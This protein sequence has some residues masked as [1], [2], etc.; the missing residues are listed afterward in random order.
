VVGG[1]LLADLG[2]S[3]SYLLDSQFY[4]DG[5]LSSIGGGSS[6]E[7]FG[8][9]LDG[10]GDDSYVA[11]SSPVGG[12]TPGGSA[13]SAVLAWGVAAA[14]PGVLWDAGGHDRLKAIVS[15]TPRMGTLNAISEA[16]GFAGL[17]GFGATILGPGTTTYELSAVANVRHSALAATHGFGEGVLGATAVVS[18]AGGNDRDR[19]SAISS[20]SR[21]EVPVTQEEH[22]S[23]NAY[24][25]ASGI[26]V[27]GAG[28]GL[29]EDLS[30]DDSFELTSRSKA[31]YDPTSL[32]G[33]E[34]PYGPESIVSPAS[35]VA[36][37]M[38]AGDLGGAGYLVDGSGD[39][40]Y[41]TRV[42]S[43]IPRGRKTR[44]L[45]Q[46]HSQAFGRVSGEGVLLDRGGRD[47]YLAQL[48]SRGSSNSSLLAHAASEGAVGGSSL[49]DLGPE[50][51]RFE[52]NVEQEVCAGSRGGSYWRGCDGFAVGM[53]P[54]V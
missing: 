39:D 14:A 27:G 10:G 8:M 11:R 28:L 36:M 54:D 24:S 44:Q 12:F 33:I 9:L 49:T 50:K 7:G 48:I 42:S 31:S 29:L 46:N 15:S 53:N 47:V 51:D 40:R 4:P 13:D 37:G 2:G 45:I 34:L 35:A 17:G 52:S 32:A 21:W 38:A 3:D 5:S 16:F 22:G 6:G 30:G 1:G 43:T 41:E 18:D 23:R 25:A 20:A 19:N 26:G